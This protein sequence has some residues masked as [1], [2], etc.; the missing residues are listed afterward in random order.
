MGEAKLT[1]DPWAEWL[2]RGR[3]QGMS[4][5]GTQR[6]QRGLTRL[7]DR[8]LAR[9]RLRPGLR[10]LDVGAGT[11]LLALDARRR[12]GPSGHVYALDI[13][14]DALLAARASGEQQTDTAPLGLL[15]GEATR[16]PFADASLDRVFTR[17]VLIYV[18]D[19][20][21][22]A[23]EFFRVLRPGGRASLFE[24]INSA[25]S[26]YDWLAVDGDGPLQEERDRVR[27]YQ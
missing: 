26:R 12:V 25:G 15:T 3:Q 8:V 1:T 27:A 6:M 18:D 4:E 24:P 5:R 2:L 9:A 17:S 11:G 16:L 10:V 22:A 19:K 21:A 20:A 13:S 14:R 7:R 23:R